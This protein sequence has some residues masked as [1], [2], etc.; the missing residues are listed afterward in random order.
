[1]PERRGSRSRA[2]RPSRRHS[3]RTHPRR[4]RAGRA[5]RADDLLLLHHGEEVALC[6]RHRLDVPVQ[7]QVRLGRGHERD[8]GVRGKAEELAALADDLGGH[9]I[10]VT[11]V[12][13][14]AHA[15]FI[16]VVNIYSSFLQRGY[17]QWIHDIALQKLSVVLC[18]DRSGLVGEDGPTHHG[19]YDIAFLRCIPNTQ[20]IAPRN[21]QELYASLWLGTQNIGPT[22]IR[23]PKGSLKDNHWQSE[24]N[25]DIA[26]QTLSPQWLKS[27]GNAHV[28][29]VSTGHA[30]N[31]AIQAAEIISQGKR[32]AP[33]NATPETETTHSANNGEMKT[34]EAIYHHLHVPVL[35]WYASDNGLSALATEKIPALLQKYSHII[36][37]EDGCIQG[38]WG[39][40]LVET[41]SHYLEKSLSHHKAHSKPQFQHLGIPHDFIEHGNNEE[42]LYHRC[43]YAPE[44]IA[45]AIITAASTK[46]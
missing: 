26:I 2:A 15:D 29:L 8:L 23:Y 42:V 30:T 18:I 27:D 44:D 41:I 1:M 21:A 17:D 10:A 25:S 45:Q 20:L 38:G 3:A 14:I 22:A 19:A 12:E 6:L 46:H 34:N 7:D 40:G 35:Q 43:G 4:A 24:I 28:L 31:L 5:A 37:V 36:T 32:T 11:Q 13:V 9:A 16:P 39:E 33:E